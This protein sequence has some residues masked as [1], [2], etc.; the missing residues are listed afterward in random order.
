MSFAI[1]CSFATLLAT[2]A[3]LPSPPFYAKRAVTPTVSGT[4]QVVGV[5]ADPTINRDSC[6]S[7]RVR[8]RELWTCRDSENYDGQPGFVYS[9]TASWSNFNGDGTPAVGDKSLLMY[10][11]NTDAYFAVQNDECGPNSGGA[12]ADSTRYALWPDTRPMPVD[13]GTDGSMS[14]YTW[15]KKAHITSTLATVTPNPATSLYRS[16]YTTDLDVNFRKLPP[17]TLVDEE[18]WSAGSIAYGDYGFVIHGSN[19]Y[20]Y[21]ALNGTEGISLARVSVSAVEDKTQYSYYT[22]SGWSANGASPPSIFDTGAAIPNAGT[23]S[24]GTFYYS[25]YFSSFVWIGAPWYGVGADF[26]ISTAPNPEGPWS[27]ATTFYTGES[28]SGEF[29]AYSQQAHPG[30]S[31]NYGNGNDI[32]LTYTKVDSTYSTPLIHVVWE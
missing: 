28:G 2:V 20:L 27:T 17:V 12:C 29:G 4:P 16:D 19:A 14:L 15:I 8:S 25:S 11:N 32:Y 1:F 26:L 22:S 5:A 23:G 7:T 24:Q 13:V 31:Q 21:G 30:L 3:A 9:S 18:F 6:T 10:G